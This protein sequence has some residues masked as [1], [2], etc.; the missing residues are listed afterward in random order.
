MV[1]GA[2]TLSSYL[3]GTGTNLR[4][5]DQS[6]VRLRAPARLH[7]AYGSGS[8]LDQGFT[9]FR[10]ARQAIRIAGATLR[11]WDPNVRPAVSNQW[12][13]TIQHQLGPSDDLASGLR[14]PAD[15]APDGSHAILPEAA[16][17]RRQLLP[18]ARTCAGTRRWTTIS[19]RSPAPHPT[20]TRPITRSR[21]CCR[22]G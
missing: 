2:Y 6:A 8:T 14:R 12:N 21:P 1:R 4:L 17:A 18:R 19:A 9:P 11:V 20:V 3:E 15:N 10:R 13:F 16:P 5:S 22:S 7:R